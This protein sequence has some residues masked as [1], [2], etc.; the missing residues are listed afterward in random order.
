M[1]AIARRGTIARKRRRTRA[2]IVAIV[3]R[4]FEAQFAADGELGK[5]VSAIL[6]DFF[7]EPIAPGYLLYEEYLAAT[8]PAG[9]ATQAKIRDESGLAHRIVLRVLPE[10]RFQ[11]K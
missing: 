5:R 1:G 11:E 10:P 4:Q 7:R 3:R 2:D 8:L 9:G 6:N